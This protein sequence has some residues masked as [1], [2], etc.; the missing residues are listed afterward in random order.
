M[1]AMDVITA[2]ARFNS[3]IPECECEY[4]V[5]QTPVMSPPTQRYRLGDTSFPCDPT[6]TL[7]TNSSDVS[8][9]TTTST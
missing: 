9:S 3:M 8:S 1:H 4:A 5:V 2:L 6:T 7:T